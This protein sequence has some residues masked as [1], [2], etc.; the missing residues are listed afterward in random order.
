[1]GLRL[2]VGLRLLLPLLEEEVAREE[3]LRVGASL[4][5]FLVSSV[6]DFDVLREDWRWGERELLGREL[7]CRDDLVRSGL[8]RLLLLLGSDSSF[9]AESFASLSVMVDIFC[10][11]LAR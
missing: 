1:M 7:L 3:R 9:A 11:L 4:V 10:G 5:L 8:L 6:G 2:L